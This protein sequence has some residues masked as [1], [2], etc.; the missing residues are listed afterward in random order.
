MDLGR[1]EQACGKTAERLREVWRSMGYDA[2]AQE[3]K[4][5]A[6][7]QQIEHVMDEAVA[8]AHMEAKE[9]DKEVQHLLSEVRDLSTHLS[10]ATRAAQHMRVFEETHSE[11]QTFA[12]KSLVERR[13]IL[14]SVRK[15]VAQH[16][17]QKRQEI[18]QVVH[19]IDVLCGRIGIKLP[20][21]KQPALID[22]FVEAQGLLKQIESLGEQA[23]EEARELRLHLSNLAVSLGTLLQDQAEIESE[24]FSEEDR[25]RLRERVAEL[26]SLRRLREARR[27]DL[28]S[29]VTQLWQRLEVRHEVRASQRERLPRSLAEE[30]LQRGEAV[31]AELR[32]MTSAR[33]DVLVPRAR[34]KVQELWDAL[35][36][37]SSA[38]EQFLAFKE[39]QFTLELLDE[40]DRMEKELRQQLA[41]IQPALDEVAR[42]VALH[43]EHQQVVESSRNPERLRKAGAFKLLQREESVRRRFRHV[44][45]LHAHALALINDCKKEDPQRRV[46]FEGRDAAELLQELA[47]SAAS[48]GNSTSSST[49]GSR[50][51]RSTLKIKRHTARVPSAHKSTLGKRS[52]TVQ[53][54]RHRARVPKRR[55][56]D[57]ESSA[58]NTNTAN[59]VATNAAKSANP[60]TGTSSSKRQNTSSSVTER[61]ESNDTTI[62]QPRR[63]R[64]DHV[65]DRRHLRKT[66]KLSR[67]LLAKHTQEEALEALG[68]LDERVR[69]IQ[70]VLP[71]LGD[72][73][74]LPQEGATLPEKVDVD[75]VCKLF[76]QRS[77][78]LGRLNRFEDALHDSELALALHRIAPLNTSVNLSV[79]RLSD[80]TAL[81]SSILAVA[82]NSAAAHNSSAVQLPSM[83][84]SVAARLMEHA[85]RT[86]RR[87]SSAS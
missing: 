87:P 64:K 34:E 47:V 58:E 41:A 50:S 57:T 67:T 60:S 29:Q 9:F 80:D 3:R 48:A 7:Q 43:K 42:V 20:T 70:D 8:A 77:I 84:D 52:H 83:S 63:P 35:G 11:A 30:E 59:T 81:D 55:R 65:V 45:K 82:S 78:A 53:L 22:Q 25:S 54:S 44:D 17:E 36:T 21:L 14:L 75:A 85:D 10:G 71:C 68:V 4:L 15:T 28:V 86:L 13:D 5:S 40:H 12:Q 16:C 31:L 6:L 26:E 73:G 46:L 61:T 72:I 76:Q 69:E 66:V 74:K 37:P 23:S 32:R 1:L 24:S 39:T 62:S 18:A 38:R 79:S 27:D 19:S 33:L 2:A 51:R 56:V 49:A